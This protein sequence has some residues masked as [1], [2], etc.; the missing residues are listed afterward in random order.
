MISYE[1]DQ[2]FFSMGRETYKVSVEDLFLANR[3]KLIAQL[4]QTDTG[5]YR[6]ERYRDT[7]WDVPCSVSDICAFL[8]AKIASSFFKA[9]KAKNASTP[10]TSLSFDKSRTFGT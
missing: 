1:N 8:Q 3:S 4:Q 7:F 5:S 9:G 10:T 2:N 6:T